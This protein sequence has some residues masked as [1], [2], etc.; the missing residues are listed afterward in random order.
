MESQNK[1]EHIQSFEVTG[2]GI[3]GD[4]RS[5]KREQKK[6]KVGLLTAGYFEYWRMYE[7][8]REKVETDMQLVADSIAPFGDLCY[9][10][11]VDTL[12]KS[13]E[14]GRYFKS[15][16]IDMLIIAEGTYCVDYLIHQTLFHLPDNIPLLIFAC[17]RHTE[18]DYNG[19]Y[20]ESLRNSGPM[21]IIQFACGLHK[22]SKYMNYEVVVGSIEDPVVYEEIALI[23]KIREIIENLKFW[24]IGLVGHIFRGMYDFQYD[25]TDVTGKFGPHIM[26]IDIKH[27]SN[28]L[29]DISLTDNRV[30]EIVKKAKSN[31][32]V[33]SL[34]DLDLQRSARL[35][36][37]LKLLVEQYR[38]DGLA[39][40]GQHFIE[41]EAKTTCYLGLSEILSEDYAIA[42]T[43]GDVLGLI[44]S[45][46]M[47][48]LTGI[49][50]FF[51]EWEEIDTKINALMI[52]GHGFIDP[53]IARKDR[54]I[55][56]QRAC[57]E[58]GFEGNAPG[59][60][61]TLTPGPV[62]LSHIIKHNDKW[63]MIITEG[64]IPDTPPL[65]ISESTVIAQVDMPVREYYK[66]LIL[67]GFS[68]HAIVVPG[69]IGNALEM[70]AKQLDVEVCWL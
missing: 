4:L 18:L 48:E 51:G 41:V 25:K 53:R 65:E 52:L 59:F 46:V 45:R 27:L 56:L 62:T 8:L 39:L 69:H 31:Y 6:L 47:K 7:G 15:Q 70:F 58:W 26:D 44:V 43:E 61:T 32:D 68:H 17:Q 21:G 49:N 28:I 40:L 55:K 20:I 22:M 57:E 38:L 11:L 10:G 30:T 23:I 19:G 60:E 13:D 37:A 1:N 42:V 50:P 29:K 35:G 5:K 3:S 63:K 33:I 64:K 24:N 66:K 16:A 12:D 67:L 36:V 2:G 9:S 14:A 34:D 54:P